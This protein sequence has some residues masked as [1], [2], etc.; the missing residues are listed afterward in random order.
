MVDIWPKPA[1]Y[2]CVVWWKRIFAADAQAF[3]MVSESPVGG[4]VGGMGRTGRANQLLLLERFHEKWR[5]S[6]E[7][8]NPGPEEG[9]EQ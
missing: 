2:S 8:A 3:V 1:S 7:T 4:R 6:F 9:A 5:Q